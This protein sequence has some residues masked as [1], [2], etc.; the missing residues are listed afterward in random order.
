[1]N[2]LILN[3]FKIVSRYRLKKGNKIK[4]DED[5]NTEYDPLASSDLCGKRRF[6]PFQFI[7]LE[8][9]TIMEVIVN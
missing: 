8:E 7:L 9:K 5:R 1:M 6:E 2:F 4:N 3:R